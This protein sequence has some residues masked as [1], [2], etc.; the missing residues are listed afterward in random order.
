MTET[1]TEIRTHVAAHPGLHFSALQSEL[2]LARGQLQYHLKKLR[3]E[4]A[5]VDEHLYG[6]T[7]YFTP[8]YSEWERRALAVVRRET[9]RD[10]LFYLL[11]RDS[12]RPAAVADDLD[13]ARS[14]LEWH[15]DR[16]IEQS[17]VEK[18]RDDG[19]RVT[20]VVTKPEATVQL[21]ETITPSLPERMVDRFTRLVDSFLA[22]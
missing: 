15:T 3:R 5:I 1:R 12:A 21:L 18:H 13:I 19:N 2:G 9:A 10:V 11:E 14:T 20:L 22:E 7:H 8:E 6:Q 17:L 16:L 4:D